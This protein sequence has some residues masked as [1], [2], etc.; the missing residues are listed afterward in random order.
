MATNPPNHQK[1]I[2][3]G[4][5][6]KASDYGKDMRIIEQWANEGIVRSLH[7]GSG[8]TL[9]PATGVDTG[10]GITISAAGG[11]SLTYSFF[12]WTSGEDS[13]NTTPPVWLSG[14]DPGDIGA[15]GLPLFSTGASGGPFTYTFGLSYITFP[16]AGQSVSYLP[17]LNAIFYSSGSVSST[18]QMTTLA[19]DF[20]NF[21]T[22]T[23]NNVPIPTATPFQLTDTDFAPLVPVVGGGDISLVAGAGTS[24]NGLVSAAGGKTYFTSITGSVT[25]ALNTTLFS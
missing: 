13:A 18:W 8:I 2:V 3:T 10:T 4:K 5:N 15:T 21:Y 7:A 24:G 23:P 9:N 25:V 20:S 16:I 12:T 11:S 1:L 14:N 17:I 6:A 22:T 19:L